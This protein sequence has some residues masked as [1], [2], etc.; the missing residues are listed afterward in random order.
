MCVTDI[1]EC[2]VHSPCDHQCN[3]IPASFICSCRPGYR[4]ASDGLK[5]DGKFA[6]YFCI[7]IGGPRRHPCTPMCPNSFV[8]HTNFPQSCRIGHLSHPLYRVGVTHNPLYLIFLN[9]KMCNMFALLYF[10]VLLLFKIVVLRYIDINECFDGTSG[11]SH[12]CTNSPGSFTCS[13]PDGYTLA[14]DQRTCQGTWV[15]IFTRPITIN[16]LLL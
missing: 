5:C 6:W 3:N 14:D 13:C 2:L 1:N 9:K 15:S 16:V 11:C 10:I 12:Q 8:L 7:I 4:L